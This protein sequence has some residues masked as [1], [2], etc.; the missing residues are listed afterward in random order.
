[1]K[2]SNITQ[3]YDRIQPTYDRMHRRFLAI[4]GAVAQAALEGV[5]I[6][7]V[8][9]GQRIL[10][11]GCGTG[12]MAR[13][14]LEAEPDAK[15]VLLDQSPS[16]LAA[17]SDV[18]ARRVHG[19]LL[20]LPFANGAF[21]LALAVWSLET[22]PSP[23]VAIG[24]LLRVTRQGGAVGLAFCALSGGNVRGRVVQRAIR[25]RKLGRPLCEDRVRDVLYCKGAGSIRRLPAQAG[26]VAL[27]AWKGDTR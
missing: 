14:L 26:T 12:G 15:V 16:M 20:S 4:S 11:A 22:I 2:N 18:S 23:E 5:V 6:A 24:E 8:R 21:D 7:A 25:L 19:S 17:A 1:M 9:P 10:D 13:R 3:N 27:V